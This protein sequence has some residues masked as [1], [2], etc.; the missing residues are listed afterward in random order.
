MKK[1]GRKDERKEKKNKEKLNRYNENNGF[2]RS[3]GF[4]VK[5]H[6]MKECSN[7]TQRQETLKNYKNDNC[8]NDAKKLRCQF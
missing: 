1:K 4:Y 7:S 6:R 5:C 2:E 8:A 3:N